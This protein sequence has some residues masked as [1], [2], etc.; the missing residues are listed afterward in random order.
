MHGPDLLYLPRDIW[1][2]GSPMRRREFIAVLG[3]AITSRPIP[4]NA[5]EPVRVRTVG[6][7]MGFANDAAAKARV[8][9]L[10]K[11]LDF[12]AGPDIAPLTFRFS[13]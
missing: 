4:A 2:W 9:A 7:L 8:E 5:Q 12:L 13:L 6:G 3:G 1:P 11:S 10:P